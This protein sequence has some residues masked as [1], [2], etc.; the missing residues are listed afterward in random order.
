ML[1]NVYSNAPR[2]LILKVRNV[3]D[4]PAVVVFDVLVNNSD[5]CN[6]G[7]FLLVRPDH[8]PRDLEFVAIDFGHCFGGPNWN[9]G[10]DGRVG[11]WCASVLPE[12]NELIGG[13]DPFADALDRL[14]LITD[15][16]LD[17]LLKQVPSNWG[18]SQDES[19]AL[20]RFILGQKGRVGGM[21][22]AFKHLFPQWR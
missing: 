19:D 12:L 22:T 10:I 17:D 7:N 20:K 3:L 18:L 16:W 13:T 8:R 4:L 9:A 15:S 5:R 21:L 1:R 2:S 14:S 11:T 6:D